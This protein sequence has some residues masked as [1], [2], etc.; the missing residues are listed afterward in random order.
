MITS[1]R[2][3]QSAQNVVRV[4]LFYSFLPVGVK[5]TTRPQVRTSM[6]VLKAPRGTSMCTLKTVAVSL[7]CSTLVQFYVSREANDC[8]QPSPAKKCCRDSLVF[9]FFSC[10]P[11]DVKEQGAR[12]VKRRAHQCACSRHQRAHQCAYL[13]Q[14]LCCRR[15]QCKYSST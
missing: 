1:T 6:C 10:L 3:H 13:R 12:H 15:R 5:I 4:N 11:K 8:I 7:T 14:W 2:S 9:L